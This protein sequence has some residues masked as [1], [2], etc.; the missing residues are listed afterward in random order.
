MLGASG[1]CRGEL[2]TLPR[3]N[4]TANTGGGAAP[5]EQRLYQRWLRSAPCIGAFQQSLL[6]L[7]STGA[8]SRAGSSTRGPGVR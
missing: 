8:G 6:C 2:S 1:T 3:D 7:E 4:L 5:P